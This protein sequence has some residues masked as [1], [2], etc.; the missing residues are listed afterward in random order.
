M[1]MVN[2]NT[3]NNLKTPEHWLDKALAVPESQKK[4]KADKSPAWQWA[5]TAAACCVAVAAVSIMLWMHSVNRQ[6]INIILTVPEITSPP[7]L[8]AQETAPAAFQPTAPTVPVASDPEA[9]TG[10]IVNIATSPDTPLSTES[11]Q[12][13]DSEQPTL[14]A[15]FSDAP[16]EPTFEATEKMTAPAAEPV[17]EQAYE[18]TEPPTQQ[19]TEPVIEYV[20]TL[21]RGLYVPPDWVVY[22]RITDLSGTVLYG[23]EDLYSEQHLCRMIERIQYQTYYTYSP[24][25]HGIL[26][27]SGCYLCV[28][29]DEMGAVLLTETVYLN[30]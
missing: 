1:R 21:Y 11:I 17:T 10:L 18:H 7:T 6:P 13:P 15:P 2:F 14:D 30:S 8:F 4:N 12:L 26:P 16:T 25:E 20:D 28:F 29:Y 3:I 22:C 19:A 24:K 5:I 23:D 27:E 9:P